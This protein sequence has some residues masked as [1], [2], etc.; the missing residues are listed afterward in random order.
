MWSVIF[1]EI[2][3][4]NS[5]RYSESRFIWFTI[6]KTDMIEQLSYIKNER[7]IAQAKAIQ[8]KR[9]GYIIHRIVCPEEDADGKVVN[10]VIAFGYIKSDT[11]R[12]KTGINVSYKDAKVSDYEFIYYN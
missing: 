5:G 1:K 12:I 4:T 2:D 3:L 9:A 8:L 6:T 10:K 11:K 7:T